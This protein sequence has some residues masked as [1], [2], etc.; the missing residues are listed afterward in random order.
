MEISFTSIDNAN[1]MTVFGPVRF[2]SYNSKIHQNRMSTYV[3]QWISGKLKL[4][5]QEILLMQNFNIQ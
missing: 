2:I 5:G 4:I 3:V 1:L